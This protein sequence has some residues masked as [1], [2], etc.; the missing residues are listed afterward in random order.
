VVLSWSLAGPFLMIRA[1]VGVEVAV[2]LLGVVILASGL[3]V[4]VA[5]VHAD[6][7]TLVYMLVQVY[8]FACVLV[9]VGLCGGNS[10]CF[11]LCVGVCELWVC[12]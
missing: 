9:C 8:V 12:V 3:L 1:E 4:Q 7:V 10:S 6:P 11:S 5:E 2:V